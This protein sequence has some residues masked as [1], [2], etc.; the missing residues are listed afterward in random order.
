M[1]KGG[2][3]LLTSPELGARMPAAWLYPFPQ[4]KPSN[5]FVYFPLSFFHRVDGGGFVFETRGAAAHKQR[6]ETRRQEC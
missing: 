5:L 2:L 4:P 6:G 3:G 1:R